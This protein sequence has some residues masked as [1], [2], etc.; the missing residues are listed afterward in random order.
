MRVRVLSNRHVVPEIL[1]EILS[2]S[3]MLRCNLYYEY[4]FFDASLSICF[5]LL[6]SFGGILYSNLKLKER[7]PPHFFS[8]TL[9][10]ALLRAET[11]VPSERR[12]AREKA[13][14]HTF[15]RARDFIREESRA[16]RRVTRGINTD[17]VLDYSRENEIF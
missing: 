6:L 1:V 11:H 13:F 10:K 12:D 8:S 9:L 17:F 5:I 2:F 15:T 4:V 7:V 3:V 16:A 14:V